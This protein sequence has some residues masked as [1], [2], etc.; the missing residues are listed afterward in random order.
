MKLIFA[1]IA[2]LGYI[3]NII[4]YQVISYI[5]WFISNSLWALYSFKKGEKE[6]MWMFITYNLFCIYGI[7]TN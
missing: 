2:I 3:L 5:I 7:I 6:I 1:I 4:D